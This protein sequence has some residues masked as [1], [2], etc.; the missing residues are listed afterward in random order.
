M[1]TGK[2][3][4]RTRLLSLIKR[5]VRGLPRGS[6]LG[7]LDGLL[8]Q[9]NAGELDPGLLAGL[10]P[11]SRTTFYS[12]RQRAQHGPEALS[13][14][15][16]GPRG[17]RVPEDQGRYI[18]GLVA[19]KPHRRP[20]R[21]AE[22]VQMK[23][24]GAA[25]SEATV[26]RFLSRWKHEQ[27][28]LYHFLRDPDAWKGCF[29]S[30]FGSACQRAE[31]YLHAVEF[32][33]TPADIRC[34]DG[35]RYK[36]VGGIDIYSR[37][38]WTTLSQ[39]STSVAIAALWRKIIISAGVF[40][41]AVVD[42]GSE[43]RSHHIIGAAER[44]GIDLPEIPPFAPEKKPHV[45][46]FFR[47]LAHGLFEELPGY[48]GHDVA[49]QQEIRNRRSFADRLME[50]GGEVAVDLAADELQEKIDLWIRAIYHQR[51]HS[52]LEMSPEAKAAK[53]TRPVRII[54][55]ER[56][57][58]ILLAPGGR[59]TVQKKGIRFR[60]GIYADTALIGAIKKKVDVRIDLGD[61]SR[62][63][64]FAGEDCEKW[65]LATGEWSECREGDFLCIARDVTLEGLTAEEA[66]HARRAQQ[67]RIREQAAAV[68]ALARGVGDPMGELLE[69]KA[70]EPGR[71]IAFKR[72]V[73]VEA[74][75]AEEASRED[76][77]STK[78]SGIDTDESAS[79][80]EAAPTITNDEEPIFE[81]GWRRY[82][83]LL[84]KKQ[85]SQEER[86]WL[87]WYRT[88]P[89][90]IEIYGEAAEG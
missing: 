48:T 85:L 73:A 89:E 37:K 61:A 82:E 23:F 10:G 12:W 56:A 18:L 78:I 14:K 80:P 32:D 63:Y 65:D 86:D 26:R 25:I 29:L 58:D 4:L 75:A 66:S 52:Q 5:R 30:S 1:E 70:K 84:K 51:P 44:L 81:Y 64:V 43:Y 7:A 68:N 17:Q 22:Y 57:L 20:A 6:K 11:I 28:S 69:Q 16:G 79:R 34:A 36:L 90:G 72:T 55:N 45:E 13:Y 53:S 60:N 74:P 87:G 76:D 24:P 88:T 49:G 54:A 21:I 71:V 9:Y 50:R 19:Q 15:K 2:E 42:N 67:K 39:H 62:I 33:T 46:R 41:V 27:E 35:L 77:L 38:A 3:G 31:Y 59:A 8:E 83:Y 40:D 47:T